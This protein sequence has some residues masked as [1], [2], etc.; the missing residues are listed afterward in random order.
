[1]NSV[2]YY[3]IMTDS[4]DKPEY[5]MQV[6][7]VPEISSLLEKLDLE[8]ARIGKSYILNLMKSC[9]AYD[10]LP[11]SNKV[12]VFDSSIPVHLAFYGLVEHGMEYDFFTLHFPS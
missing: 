3:F 8:S 12:V 2:L 11:E 9:T 6:D 10:V 7:D 5:S 1:M 4:D